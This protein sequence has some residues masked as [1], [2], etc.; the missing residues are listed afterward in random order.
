VHA[1]TSVRQTAQSSSADCCGTLE[2]RELRACLHH[3][4]SLPVYTVSD[5]Q[6]PVLLLLQHQ[7]MERRLLDMRSR[8]GAPRFCIVIADSP[9]KVCYAIRCICYNL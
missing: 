6:L 9:E 7:P 2:T 3:T 4:L 5:L 1:E 8:T